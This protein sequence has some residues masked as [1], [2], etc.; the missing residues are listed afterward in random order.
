MNVLVVEDNPAEARLTEEAFAEVGDDFCLTHVDTGEEALQVLH[1]QHTYRNA[2][3]PDLVLLDLNLPGKDGREV[4][5]EIK[6]SEELRSIPVIVVSNSNAPEDI[7]RVYGLNGNCYL[8]KPGDVD[9]FFEMIRK[10]IDFWWLMA[11]SSD[12]KA[13][14][15]TT[16]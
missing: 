10:L 16:D 13:G 9:E 1:H 8:V 15:A 14:R 3:R 4:L 5:K 6:S 2:A 12:P 7:R 11:R